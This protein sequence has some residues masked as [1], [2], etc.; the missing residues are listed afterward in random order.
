MATYIL[1]LPAALPPL[2][3]PSALPAVSPTL[4]RAAVLALLLHVWLVL[5]LGNA[6][7]GTARPGQGVW[8]AINVTL[9]GA[10]SAGAL[11]LAPPPVPEGP[12]GPAVLPRWGGTVR[13]HAA[14]VPPEPGAAQV[15]H[16]AATPTPAAAAPAPPPPPGRVVEERAATPPLARTIT[17]PAR[18]EAA[19]PAPSALAA[20]APAPV[21][22]KEPAPA[23]D[24]AP[25]PVALKE[26]AAA[27]D[28]APAPAAL[29]DPAPAALTVPA[30]AVERSL[31]S[32]PAPVQNDATATAPLQTLPLAAA[33]HGEPVPLPAP[34]PMLSRLQRAPAP[35]APALAP[36]ARPAALEALRPSALAL[37]TLPALGAGPQVPSVTPVMAPAAMPD[38]ALNATAATARASARPGAPDAGQH[39]G[40]D[41]ATPASAAPAVPPRLNLQLARPRGGELSR[42]SAT[43]A[44]PLLPRPPE[45]PDKL[46]RDIERSARA[47]C[48]SA[49]AGAGLLAVVPLAADALRSNGGCKW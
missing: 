6:P 28:Q 12:P 3:L 25:A 45:L 27:P 9:R 2:V 41:A 34:A 18:H 36:L 32:M 49:Y 30:P 4:A 26:P 17:Q 42:F 37:P 1:P 29:N 16:W 48:R 13:D 14:A 20:P 21:A 11:D 7:G 22:L 31:A 24:Q 38:A 35:L 47:D 23:P 19:A 46:A 15:G 5:L 40:A 44:L 33:P 43:G 10:A 8:G 39:A